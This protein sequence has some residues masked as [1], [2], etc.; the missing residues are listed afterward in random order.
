MAFSKHHL[1]QPTD[2]IIAGYAHAFGHA[3]RVI[4]IKQLVVMGPSTVQSM[5]VYHPIHKESL[6]DHIKI[7]RHYDLVEWR[8]SYPYTIYSAHL[9]N[10]KKACKFLVDYIEVIRPIG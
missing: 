9:E 7:L 2:Q 6:S 10:I 3:A 4:I 1:Y 5:A 8:E